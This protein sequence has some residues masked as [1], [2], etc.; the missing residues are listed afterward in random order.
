M[1]GAAGGLGKAD[2]PLHHDHLGLVRNAGKPEPGRHGP[3]VHQAVSGE[4]G[5][6][7]ILDD[8]AAERAH[9]SHRPAHH[10]AVGDGAMAIGEADGTRLAKERHFGELLAGA[11]LGDGAVGVDLDPLLLPCAS[12]DELDHRRV[13]DRR[14]GVGQA[15]K[16]GDPARRR[17]LGAALERLLVL[18][19]RL[20]EQHAHVDQPGC[21]TKPV[22]IDDLGIDA[23]AVDRKMLA[24]ACDLAAGDQKIADLIEPGCR[25]EQ[26]CPLDQDQPAHAAAFRLRVSVSR[27]AMRTATPSST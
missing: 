14:L 18:G 27:Q 3:L 11:A 25:I 22:G 16:A 19:T 1:K 13:V 21:E 4:R 17:R 8:A 2:V 5:V 7:R 9:I 23:G 20:A 10:Q 26:P 12:C 24:E 15:G 6:F